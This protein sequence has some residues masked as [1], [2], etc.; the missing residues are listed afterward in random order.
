[1]NISKIIAI[2]V[3]VACLASVSGKLPELIK[4]S[5]NAQIQILDQSRSSAWGKAWIP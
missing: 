5:R 4:A 3:S 2:A 1:M